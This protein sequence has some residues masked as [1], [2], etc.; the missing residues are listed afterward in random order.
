MKLPQVKMIV[1]CNP[2]NPSGQVF[3]SKQLKPLI[4]AVKILNI[5]YFS[6]EIFADLVFGKFESALTFGLPQEQCIVADS[7]SKTF[8]VESLQCGFCIIP[9]DQFRQKYTDMY[10]VLRMTHTEIAMLLLEICYSEIGVSWL[11]EI[12]LLL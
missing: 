9:G 7:I 3:T 6:D 12:K 4:E 5:I 10:D 1:M 8:N 2:H 11:S